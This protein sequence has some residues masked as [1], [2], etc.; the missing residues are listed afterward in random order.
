VVSNSGIP[1]VPFAVQLGV[2]QPL[3]GYSA[4]PDSFN[5]RVS[6]PRGGRDEHATARIPGLAHAA[7][8]NGAGVDFQTIPG[9]Q[10]G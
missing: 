9:S 3:V 4:P 8:Y 6:A 1:S 10:A 2:A 5:K 7:I